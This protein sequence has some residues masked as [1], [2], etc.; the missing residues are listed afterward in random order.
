MKQKKHFIK[1]GVFIKQIYLLR[2]NIMANSFSDDLKNVML[3]GFG[4]ATIAAE[5]S[6]ELISTLVEKGELTV[7]QGKELMEKLVEKGGMTAQNGKKVFDSL[8]EKGE[9]S[10]K[11]SKARNEEI[12]HINEEKK[13]EKNLKSVL[14]NMEGMTKEQ[15]DVIKKRLTEIEKKK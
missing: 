10:L 15:I 7:E 14:E 1:H 6:K 11:K 8:V 9:S 5:K 13:K 12:R 4:A 2:S 3:A